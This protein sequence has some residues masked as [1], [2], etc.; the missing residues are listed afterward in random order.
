MAFALLVVAIPVALITTNVRFAAS[1]VRLYDYSVREYDA[2]SASRIPE[3]ELIR[4]NRSLVSY[5]T[6]ENAPPLHIVVT[7]QAGEEE[8]LFNARETVHLADV[9]DVF[10]TLFKL[11]V[12]SV[13]L[14]LTLAVVLFTIASLRV[15]AQALMFGAVLTGGLVAA[16]GVVASLGFD[17]AWH[18]LH[19]LIFTNDLWLLDP[20]SD[21]LIQMFPRDF[22]FEVT[23]L[24]GAF[25]L[26]QALLISGASGLYLLVTR[27]A[28]PAAPARY[29][30]QPRSMEPRPR[31]PPPRPRHITH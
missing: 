20:A 8:A 5:L 22:W 7:N 12:A 11:Q 19:L 26:F 4:A 25:T 21:H 18:D 3:S 28:E 29:V 23:L 30:P 6:A 14:V 24:I 16:T 2:A 17:G 27:S 13:A 9:R 1:E 15:L 31:I 10:Q